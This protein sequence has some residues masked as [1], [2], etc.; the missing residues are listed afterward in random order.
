MK[1]S[2]I[3]ILHLGYWLLYFLLLALFF[4]I[5]GLQ[6][7]KSSNFNLWAALPLIILCV[8]PN[9]LS[10]Y[11]YYSLIFTRFFS[12][13]EFVLASIFGGLLSLATAIFA[14]V[15]SLFLFG[16]NQPIFSN[17]ADFFPMLASFFL[18][19]TIHG[20]IALVIRGFITWFDEIRLKEELTKKNYET[21]MALLKSQ[22]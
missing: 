22:L 18:L 7:E 11:L 4:F 9:L 16:L 10:F 15:I 19:A 17:A 14:L 2:I 12:Q 5:I 13:Q 8:L 1:R 3:L 6:A 20:G 21:E